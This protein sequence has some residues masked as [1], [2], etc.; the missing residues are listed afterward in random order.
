MSVQEQAAKMKEFRELARDPNRAAAIVRKPITPE[1]RIL[2]SQ[3]L[4]KAVQSKRGE[5]TEV[6]ESAKA[7][8]EKLGITWADARHYMAALAKWMKA[9]FPTRTDEEVERIV[10][11]CQSNKCRGYVGGRCRFCGCQVNTGPAIVNKARMA[12]EDCPKKRWGDGDSLV[13]YE[14]VN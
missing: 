5:A 12:T 3:N 9:G 4:M 10:S 11:I 14:P 6:V 7:G 2:R 1:D 13:S 8:A